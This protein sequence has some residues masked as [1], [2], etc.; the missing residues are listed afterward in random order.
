[1]LWDLFKQILKVT[2]Y[3]DMISLCCFNHRIHHSIYYGTKDCI[4]KKPV[5]SS[6]RIAA[7]NSFNIL[8]E[9][10]DNPVEVRQKSL[11]WDNQTERKDN[12]FEILGSKQWTITILN[13]IFRRK[14]IEFIFIIFLSNH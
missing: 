12:N 5:G 11:L 6:H 10:S 2:T 14:G 8:S 3:I 9:Y 4:R 13:I 1:M 7:Y